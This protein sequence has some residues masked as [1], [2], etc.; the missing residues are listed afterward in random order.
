MSEIPSAYELTAINNYEVGTP[1]AILLDSF[2]F[3][4]MTGV[5][6]SDSFYDEKELG[7][8]NFTF[9]RIGKSKYLL[10]KAVAIMA[11]VFL[12]LS[13][14]LALSQLLAMFAFPVQGHLTSRITYNELMKPDSDRIFAY[15]ENYYPYWNSVIFIFIRSLTGAI[16]ALLT[17][18]ITFVNHA[19]KYIILL[20]PMAFYIIYSLITSIISSKIP[21][22]RLGEIVETNVL[23]VNGYGSIWVMAMYLA[24]CAAVGIV[25][26]LRGMK[27]DETLL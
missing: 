22:I 10:Y 18:A 17:F 16:I 2:L 14:V 6:A 19:K 3:F 1:V 8:H 12:M 21:S 25:L 26:I 4:L 20:L 11:V 27:H 23:N 9:T 7:I 24:V 15:F 5:I 13:F